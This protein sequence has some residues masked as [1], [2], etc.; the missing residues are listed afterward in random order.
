MIALRFAAPDGRWSRRYGSLEKARAEAQRLLG[1]FPEFSS[2]FGYAVSPYGTTLRVDGASLEDLFPKAA[3]MLAR[4]REQEAALE[5]ERAALPPYEECEHGL[6]A[7]L[8]GGPMHWY[9]NDAEMRAY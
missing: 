5:A 1:E 7:Q 9:D 8:C 2:T 6:D 3:A 4:E